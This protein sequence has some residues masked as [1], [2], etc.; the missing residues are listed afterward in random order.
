MIEKIK[1]SYTMEEKDRMKILEAIQTKNI[2]L[3][4]TAQKLGICASYL[5]D[6]M[7]GNRYASSEFVNA[8]E[9]FLEIQLL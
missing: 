5:S 4:K 6:I 1:I 9:K 2:S 8:L 3:R 7:Y